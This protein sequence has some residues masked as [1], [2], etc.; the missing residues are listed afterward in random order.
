MCPESPQDSVAPTNINEYV[1]FDTPGETGGWTGEGEVRRDDIANMYCWFSTD[2]QRDFGQ[3][4]PPSVDVRVLIRLRGLFPGETLIATHPAGVGEIKGMPFREHSLYLIQ[5][6]KADANGGFFMQ[7][8]LATGQTM[9]IESIQ[10]LAP[11]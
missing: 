10:I 1:R 9:S 6:A 7:F 4:L 8:R 11:V 5:G 3:Q 2:A